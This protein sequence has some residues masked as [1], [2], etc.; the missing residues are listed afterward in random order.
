[1]KFQKPFALI[2]VLSL[3]L[4]ASAVQKSAKLTLTVAAPGA[5]AS[6]LSISVNGKAATATPTTP[7]K[8][9]VVPDLKLD[10]YTTE[11]PEQVANPMIFVFDAMDTKEIEDRDMRKYVLKYMSAAAARKESVGLLVMYRDGVLTIHDYRAGSAVLT[12]ALAQVNGGSAPPVPGAEQQIAIETRRLSAFA[13]GDY[14][15]KAG[16]ETLLLTTLESPIYMVQEVAAGLRDVP[17]RKAIVWITAGVPFEIDERDHSLTSHQ[18]MNNGASVNGVQVQS[19]KR[20][21]TDDQIRK[22]QPMWRSALFNLWDSGTAVYPVEALSPFSPPAGRVYTST[23]NTFAQMTGGR[24]FYGT[25]D[26]LPFFSSIASD[27]ANSAS[28]TLSFEASSDNWQKL[29]VSSPKSSKVLAPSGIF[30][31]PDL[32]PEDARKKAVGIALN[33]RF[34]FAGVPFRLTLGEQ[35]ANGSKKS[36][37]F[38]VF[39]PPNAGVVN[40]KAGEISLEIAA[41]AIGKKSEKAGVMGAGAGGKLPADALK[42]ITEMGVNISKTIDVPPGEYTLR[43]V[44]RDNLTGRIGSIEAYLKVE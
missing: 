42:Q 8:N 23:M 5:A 37:K 2:S 35:T 20:S 11:L 9:M 36:V 15:T 21:A 44:V 27:N 39:V 6:D 3:S 16:D 7:I 17:G 43:V 24:A 25:N 30:A 14:S 29:N 12:A 22:L 4:F 33:S 34:G 19:T 18:E 38:S 26:P 10:Q 32:T 40:E 31:P 28:V 13:K 1:M 41:L